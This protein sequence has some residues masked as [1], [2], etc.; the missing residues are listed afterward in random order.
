MLEA[1]S[2]RADASSPPI[3][4]AKFVPHNIEVKHGLHR[5]YRRTGFDEEFVY[6]LRDD[7][8][9]VS[10]NRRRCGRVGHCCISTIHVAA[11]WRWKR[12][13]GRIGGVDG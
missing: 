12:S 8:K 3:V 2:A 11:R 6:V 9:G 7:A 5:T 1:Q 13:R 4:V 10:L